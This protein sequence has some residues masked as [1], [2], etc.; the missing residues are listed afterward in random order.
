MSY[1]GRKAG[2]D[3]LHKEWLLSLFPRTRGDGIILADRRGG[4]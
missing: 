4:K 3:L 1:P 2:Q